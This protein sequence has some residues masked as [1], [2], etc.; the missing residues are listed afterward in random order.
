MY[1]VYDDKVSRLLTAIDA[2]LVNEDV[3][4]SLSSALVLHVYEEF[5]LGKCSG[6]NI[7][8]FRRVLKASETLDDNPKLI[9]YLAENILRGLEG[10]EEASKKALKMLNLSTMY[11]RERVVLYYAFLALINKIVER[12]SLAQEH[13]EI[14]RLNIARVSVAAE[15]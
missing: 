8:L 6:W 11:S 2:L 3:D 12:R 5:G 4:E 9:L 10:D 15:T 7:D 14:P 13:A 1:H